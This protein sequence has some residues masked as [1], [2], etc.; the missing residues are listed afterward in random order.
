MT[1]AELK[2]LLD[3]QEEAVK[4]QGRNPSDVIVF[5]SS[6][7]EGNC[8][9]NVDGFSLGRYVVLFPKHDIVEPDDV[10]EDNEA[11]EEM[12]LDDFLPSAKKKP[13]QE[14]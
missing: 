2:E 3:E 14:S 10:W 13:C 4:A 12:V 6:D 5:M 11:E 8:Y 9:H 7:A 1:L